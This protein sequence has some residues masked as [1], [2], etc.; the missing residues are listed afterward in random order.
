VTCEV[1]KCNECRTKFTTVSDIKKTHQRKAYWE[2]YF[3]A[4]PEIEQEEFR[5][6]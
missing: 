6:F 2:K 1:Y 4:P 3:T 5:I